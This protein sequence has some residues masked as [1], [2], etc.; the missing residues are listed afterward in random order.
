MNHV[1]CWLCNELEYWSLNYRIRELVDNTDV[2]QW[3]E[4][5]YSQ[6]EKLL[7]N[8]IKAAE[9]LVKELRKYRN[10]NKPLEHIKNSCHK[11]FV[12][13]VVEMEFRFEVS[14]VI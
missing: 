5:I 6:A 3:N 12:I 14:N 11:D 13:R 9:D 2:N 4:S 8:P 10:I 1:E 7:Q